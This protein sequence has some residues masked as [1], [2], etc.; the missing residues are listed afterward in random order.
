MIVARPLVAGADELWRPQPYSTWGSQSSFLGAF[1]SSAGL[2][3]WRAGL[4]APLPLRLPHKQTPWFWLP[5]FAAKPSSKPQSS[6]LRQYPVLELLLRPIDRPV[7]SRRPERSCAELETD[8]VKPLGDIG[9]ERSSSSQD[10]ASRAEVAHDLLLP[11]DPA[12]PL[13]G[14]SFPAEALSMEATRELLSRISQMAPEG[15]EMVDSPR[16]LQTDASLDLSDE[17]EESP[18]S[19]TSGREPTSGSLSFQR[20]SCTGSLT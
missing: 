15:W 18:R 7:F 6:F 14:S 4:L 8:D 19:A 1:H 11:A 12:Y 17:E 13:S 20:R 2:A 10:L 5:G 16:S 3:S 9:A